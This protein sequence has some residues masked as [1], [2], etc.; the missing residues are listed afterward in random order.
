MAEAIAVE[1]ERIIEVQAQALRMLEP[2]SS[3]TS[4][5]PAKGA[6]DPL[7]DTASDTRGV[8]P[9]ETP[10]VNPVRPAMGRLRK[11]LTFGR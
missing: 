2:G 10:L 9:D 6:S 7:S 1:R 3:G 5:H 4:K 11:L 8:T